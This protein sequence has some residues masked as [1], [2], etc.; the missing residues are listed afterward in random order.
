MK[1][2][3]VLLLLASLGIMGI[4]IVVGHS[5]KAAVAGHG[6][7]A[8]L[9]SDAACFDRWNAGQ[10]INICSVP[11]TYCYFPMITNGGTHTVSANGDDGTTCTASSVD[12]YDQ[13]ATS[14]KPVRLFFN[15]GNNVTIGNVNVPAFGSLY[16]CC[17]MNQNSIL[18]SANW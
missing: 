12:A 2:T 10:I 17:T 5:S 14:T 8:L 7:M 13:T 11:K 3:R 4:A 6:G 15:G 16:L 18:N 1:R 9:T